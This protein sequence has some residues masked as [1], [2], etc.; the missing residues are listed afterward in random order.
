[1]PTVVELRV[2]HTAGFILQEGG[3]RSQVKGRTFLQVWKYSNSFAK[4]GN[5]HVNTEHDTMKT[6]KEEKKKAGA[7]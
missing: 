7:Y 6:E 4:E 3:Y 1:M 2:V 5:L